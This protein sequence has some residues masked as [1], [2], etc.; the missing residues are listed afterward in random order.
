MNFH[1]SQYEILIFFNKI[2][3]TLYK[4]LFSRIWKLYFFINFL[5]NPHFKKYFF[6]IFV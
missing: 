6:K 1:Y 2:F 5:R 4:F 3:K